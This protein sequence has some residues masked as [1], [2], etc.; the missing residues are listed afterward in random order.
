MFNVAKAT[1]NSHVKIFK[2]E[3]NKQHIHLHISFTERNNKQTNKHH[4]LMPR[5]MPIEAFQMD[6]LRTSPSQQ[7]LNPSRSS[8]IPSQ[9]EEIDQEPATNEARPHRLDL[10]SIPVFLLELL[11]LGGLAYSA[12]FIHFQ[13]KHEPLIS[14]FYCDDISLRQHFVESKIIQQFSRQDN[15][16][17]I[18][19]LFLAVPVVLVSFIKTT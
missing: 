15:E 8:S 17:V 5:H 11:V 13:Y 16:L 3:T 6:H 12:Y 7:H 1:I 4:Q 19:V 10:Y 18:V 2:K 14:G 9:R